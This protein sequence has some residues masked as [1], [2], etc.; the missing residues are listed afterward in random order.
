MRAKRKV[1]IWLTRDGDAAAKH[2]VFACC[3]P[4]YKRNPRQEIWVCNEDCDSDVGALFVCS[5]AAEELLGGPMKGGP[6][7]IRRLV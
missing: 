3:K 1:E 5:Q 2:F 7:S 4:V 6:R